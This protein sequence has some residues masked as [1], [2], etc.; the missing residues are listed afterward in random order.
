MEDLYPKLSPITSGGK[1]EQVLSALQNLI[2]DENLQPGTELPSERELSE[3]LQ[4][5]RFSIREALRVAQAQGLIEIRRGKKPTVSNPS[6]AAAAEVISLTLRRSRKP[7]LDLIIARQV[8]ECQI[9]R[10][11]A[12]LITKPDIDSMQETINLMSNNKE[13]LELCTEKDIEFH[14]ILL[15][16][17]DNVVFEIMIAPVSEL[18]KKSRSITLMYRGIDIAISAH[19]KILA[20]VRNHDPQAAYEAMSQHLSITEKTIKE[21]EK[22]SLQK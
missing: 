19:T 5:S 12:K 3:Q 16:A 20:A 10:Y 4:V 8:L 6:A 21:I 7:F 9:A 15:K 17:S 18:L 11:A 13:N 1:I 14:N 2:I 22:Q